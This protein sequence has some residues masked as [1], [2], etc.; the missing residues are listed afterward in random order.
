M[1]AATTTRQGTNQLQACDARERERR[2]ADN[3][4]KGERNRISEKTRARW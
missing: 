2:K 4:E 1:K 3:E